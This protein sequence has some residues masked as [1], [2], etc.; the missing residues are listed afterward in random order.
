MKDRGKQ[1]VN[2]TVIKNER[3]KDREKTIN[4]AIKNREGILF[5]FQAYDYETKGKILQ[6][7]LIS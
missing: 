2:Q 1:T 7:S 4:Q 6:F 3:G 5:L